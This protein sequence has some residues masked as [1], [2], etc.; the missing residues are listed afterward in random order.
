M[1]Y[2]GDMVKRRVMSSKGK[3][4]LNNIQC[5]SPIIAYN[6]YM[7]T[8]INSFSTLLR[9]YHHTGTAQFFFLSFEDITTTNAYIFGAHQT[10]QFTHKILKGPHRDAGNI[11]F[12][13]SRPVNTLCI[14][15]NRSCFGEWH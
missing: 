2:A 10:P 12:F 5:P 14:I 3:W 6:K 1:P 8:P 15:I 13:K 11:F 9:K 4:E 7:G